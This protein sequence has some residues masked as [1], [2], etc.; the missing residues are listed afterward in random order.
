MWMGQ[1]AFVYYYPAIDRYL[2]QFP[3]GIGT[4]DPEDS[5]AS[6]IAGALCAQFLA[7]DIRMLL[8]ILE[9][10]RN[11][12]SYVRS[13]LSQ[14]ATCPENQAEIDSTWQGLESQLE[15]L[16]SRIQNKA[17]PKQGAPY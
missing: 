4:E 15:Q 5:S 7:S 12:V 14:L 3:G 8:P 10:V 9:Q 2:R 13:H 16:S 6:A 11:L 1:P 17:K